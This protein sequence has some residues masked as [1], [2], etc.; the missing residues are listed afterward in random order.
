M[1]TDDFMFIFQDETPPQLT[2]PSFNYPGIYILMKIIIKITVQ[3]HVKDGSI[4]T[5]TVM[6]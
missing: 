2:S 6:A 4:N 1:L 5:V 3:N